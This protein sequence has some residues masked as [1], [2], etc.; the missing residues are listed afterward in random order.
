MP[1]LLEE[2]CAR[3][4]GLTQQEVDHFHRLAAVWQML[5]DLSFADLL[6]LAPIESD[7]DRDLLLL[8]Q[9]RPLTAQ[10]LYPDDHVG[11]A[12]LAENAPEAVAAL[13]SGKQRRNKGDPRGIHRAAIPVRVTER[14]P[15]VLLR[16]GMPFG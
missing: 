5:A 8:A 15:A 10:T 11:S 7:P 13:E 12:L 4:G 3:A 2:L 14:V 16:E 9:I 6:L 1:T